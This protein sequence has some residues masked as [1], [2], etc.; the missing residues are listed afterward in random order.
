MSTTTTKENLTNKYR[1]G[2]I[3]F[4]HS[5]VKE[6]GIIYYDIEPEVKGNIKEPIVK[7][8]ELEMR[9]LDWCVPVG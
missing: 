4:I 7:I 5:G 8:P 6:D 9:S 1:M 3:K 2:L